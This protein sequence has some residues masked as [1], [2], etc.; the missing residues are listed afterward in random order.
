VLAVGRLRPA[1]RQAADDYLRRLRRFATVTEGEAREAGR[2]ASGAVARRKEGERLRERLPAGAHLVALDRA[3]RAMTSEEVARRIGDWER[4][5]NPVV[6]LIGGSEGLQPELLADCHERWSFGPLT[7]PHE[8]ARVVAYEQ[9][10]RG[11]T[12]LRGQ[13]Y[14][15]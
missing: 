5:A 10:Y 14:H 13:R 8:L 15:K 9:L 12:M 11:F 2:E 6:L 1:F 3:G 7:L 4:Q